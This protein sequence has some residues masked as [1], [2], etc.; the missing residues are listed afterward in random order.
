MTAENK[1]SRRL[2]TTAPFMDRLREK[3]AEGKFVC[4]GLDTDWSKVP[5]EYKKLGRK[6]GTFQYNKQIADAVHGFVAAFK[7]N[8]AFYEDDPEAEAGL[9]QSVDYIH[10]KRGLVIADNK[11]G[12]IGNTNEGYVKKLFGRYGFDAI[13]INGYV[14]GA[15]LEPF[16]NL[17]DKGVFV[18]CRTS[19]PGSDEF[20]ALQISIDSLTK[21]PEELAEL[22]RLGRGLT[23]PMYL[24]VARKVSQWNENGNLGLVIGATYPEE[25]ERVREADD[26]IPFLVPALGAQGGDTK[27]AVAST[28]D[29]DGKGAVYN[30]S[31]GIIFAKRQEDETVGEAAL[32]ETLKLSK[33]INYYRENPEGMTDMTRELIKR[34]LPIGGIK[35][36]EFRLKLHEKDPTAPL[37]PVYIDLRVLRSADSFTRELAV[38]VYADLIKDLGFDVIADVPTGV[39][40]IAAWLAESIKVPLITPRV[41][42]KEHGTGAKVDGIYTP[43]KTVALVIEDVVTSGASIGG[44]VDVLRNAGVI[45]N[46]YAA[47]I[48][49][50]QGGTA[51]LR[52]K[53]LNGHIASTLLDAMKSLKKGG[54]MDSYTYSK[55]YNYSI[56]NR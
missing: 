26:K 4:V 44:G 2:P 24:Q 13:T 1:P 7:P 10:K 52:S 8:L 49:R 23:I 18:L 56:L 29:S 20:Q 46:D 48:D 38:K 51:Y 42:K 30:S 45:V 16:T 27:K 5:A 3:W 33:E 37:S 19:N 22:L 21:D 43:G 9:L 54:D 47:L 50:E 15:A 6:E 40:P 11:V 34:L 36:G 39:S 14:G 28:I 31:R 12:D 32:R 17:K 35:F 53:G 25:A 55:V 41:D